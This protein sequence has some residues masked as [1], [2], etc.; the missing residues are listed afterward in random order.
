M[1]VEVP[2]GARA[3][4]PRISEPRPRSVPLQEGRWQSA[5]HHTGPASRASSARVFL[6]V[7]AG[8]LFLHLPLCRRRWANRHS[9]TQ[10]G[11]G[12]VQMDL[13]GHFCCSGRISCTTHQ[14]LELRASILGCCQRWPILGFVGSE[15]PV[16]SWRL[17]Y[18]HDERIA[19]R[20]ST[21]YTHIYIYLDQD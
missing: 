18:N 15:A 16:D 5:L 10:C 1:R 13:E 6:E 20:V 17:S 21:E 8:Q 2:L 19:R 3:S 4:G 9:S 7:I 11:E 12:R 14:Q